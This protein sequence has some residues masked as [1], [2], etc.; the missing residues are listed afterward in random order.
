MLDFTPTM[1]TSTF[2]PTS[3]ITYPSEDQEKVNPGHLYLLQQRTFEIIQLVEGPPPPRRQLSSAISSSEASSSTCSTEYKDSDSLS[4]DEDC[5]SVCSSYCSSDEFSE[6]VQLS[7]DPEMPTLDD[8][9][10]SRMKRVFAWRE[11][12]FQA[13]NIAAPGMCPHGII[14]ITF[15]STS[16]D[17]PPLKRKGDDHAEPNDQFVRLITP[18]HVTHQLTRR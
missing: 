16:P 7:Q 13:M 10:S 6:D 5:N 2:S 8:T 3:D 17:H 4:S 1:L 14:P 11:T 9:Y 15:L 18:F 12:F